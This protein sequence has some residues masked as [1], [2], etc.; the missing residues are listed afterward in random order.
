MPEWFTLN[1]NTQL[2]YFNK[3]VYKASVLQTKKKFEDNK[4]VIR[5]TT[6]TTMVKIKMTK[7]QTMDGKT[8]HWEPQNEQ[9]EPNK[10]PGVKSSAGLEG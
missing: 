2:C 4:V 7:M 6:D 9:H 3:L 5:R 10:T 1:I 8:I